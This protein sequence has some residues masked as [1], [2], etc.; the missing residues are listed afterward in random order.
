MEAHQAISSLIL[1]LTK[2]HQATL[3]Y[4]L[5]NNVKNLVFCYPLGLVEE[6][7]GRQIRGSRCDYFVAA[8]FFQDVWQISGDFFVTSTHFSSDN[9]QPIYS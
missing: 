1:P 6:W 2:A 3:S 7:H 9:S 4:R 5:E 8:P